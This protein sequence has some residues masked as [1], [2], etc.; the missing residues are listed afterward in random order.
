MRTTS[1]E[2]SKLNRYLLLQLLIT[3]YVIVFEVILYAVRKPAG[4][5]MNVTVREFALFLIICAPLFFGGFILCTTFAVWMKGRLFPRFSKWMY[6]GLASL[7]FTALYVR[8]TN[9]IFHEQQNWLPY[10]YIPLTA[11]ILFFILYELYLTERLP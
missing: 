9:S 6:W 3:I 2:L 7:V 8:M 11:F 4:G 1:R 5:L 10:A